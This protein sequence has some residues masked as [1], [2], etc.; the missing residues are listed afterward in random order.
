MS[1][2]R[3]S[4]SVIRLVA[5]IAVLASLIA[6]APA[7]A[8]T[9][10][11]AVS[12]AKVWVKKRVGYS[13]RRYFQGYRR[14]CSG[15]VS[16]AWKAKTSYTTRTLPKVSRRIRAKSRIRPGDLMLQ[17]GHARLF[18]GWANKSKT[19]FISLEQSS[20]KRGAIRRVV[21]YKGHV[22]YRYKWMK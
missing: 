12:R 7:H 15:F 18:A 17:P 22:A 20:R 9:S 16:M 11:Q 6:P 2:V 13:Q 4:L 21:A 1:A 19:K 5:M 8:V 3:K 14:D 10:T